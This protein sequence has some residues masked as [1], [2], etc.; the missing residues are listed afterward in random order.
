M[1]STSDAR[2]QGGSLVVSQR[3]FFDEFLSAL[4]LRLEGKEVIDSVCVATM[5]QDYGVPYP[6]QLGFPPD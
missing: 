6:V 5:Y 4:A 3:A 1:L 2:G